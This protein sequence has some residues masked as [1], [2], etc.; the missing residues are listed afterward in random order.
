MVRMIADAGFDGASVYFGDE[1][2]ARKATGLL[3]NHGLTSALA[4]KAGL[5]RR[6]SIARFVAEADISLSRLCPNGHT[7]CLAQYAAEKAATKA[8]A[9]QSESP[10]QTA[11]QPVR[12]QMR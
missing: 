7:V 1:N 2:Y 5:D 12:P 10:R 9:R 8:S 3:K 4:S 11:N 6:Y